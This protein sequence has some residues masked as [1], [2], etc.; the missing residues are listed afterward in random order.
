MTETNVSAFNQ[1]WFLV[2][3]TAPSEK[4][5][6]DFQNGRLFYD[7]FT[8]ETQLSLIQT[9]WINGTSTIRNVNMLT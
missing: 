9:S 6:T 1:C 5:Q 8:L 7:G 4:Q 3:I 2:V